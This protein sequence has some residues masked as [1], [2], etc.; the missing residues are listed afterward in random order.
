MPEKMVRVFAVAAALTAVAMA[1]PAQE[2]ETATPSVTSA[3]NLAADFYIKSRCDEPDK[4]SLAKPMSTD[5]DDVL[6]YNQAI[7][8][9]NSQ[10]KALDAC[11][12]AY[13]DKASS[14]IDWILFTVNMAAARANGSNPPPPPAAPGN[15][16]SG[17]YPP[18]T[19]ITPDRQLGTAPDGRDTRAMDAYNAKVRTFNASAIG[20]NN[21]I[22][23][24]AA[25][26]QVDIRRIEDAQKN[27]VLQT[28]GQ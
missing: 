4:I 15:M 10:L 20:F 24:Y 27:A 26:A 12:H 22:R 21:C 25:R 18:P 28:S 11:I 23:E 2:P 17:F 9:Y 16:S 19:C 13:A 14:D 5:R 3:G 7:R 8:R 6:R 1:A